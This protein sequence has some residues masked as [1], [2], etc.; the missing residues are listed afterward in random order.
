LTPE[1]LDL[2]HGTLSRRVFLVR[3][4]A[5]AGG[6]AAV[7]A[8]TEEP[9]SCSPRSTS[10]QQAASS[11]AVI[12]SVNENDLREVTS[13]ILCE[14]K[15]GKTVYTGELADGC[16]VAMQM[17]A[18]AASYLSQGMTPPQVLEQFVA[19]FGEDV[20][21]APTKEGLNLVVWLMPIVGL[22]A[23][24]AVATKA[25]AT[26]RQNAATAV[27]SPPPETDDATLQRIEEEIHRDF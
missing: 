27:A 24:I 13:N 19:D 20:L 14:G 8:L 2:S 25:M 7:S 4:L 15:C 21:A 1:R 12:A 26:W 5:V 23:G 3:T 9:A 22:G 16:E 10:A 17:K 11:E 18:Q 6:V